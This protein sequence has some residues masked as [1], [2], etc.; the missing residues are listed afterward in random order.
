MAIL[1]FKEIPAAHQATGLQD[2]FE[3]FARDFLG[4]LGYK[5]VVD[6]S[7]GADG[8][9]DLIV[10]E[11]RTGIGGETVVRWLVSCKHKAHSGASVNA[12]DDANIR[13]RVEAHNCKGFIGFYSTLASAGLSDSL[14]GMKSRLECQ[15][16]D[17]EKI[18]SQI[19]NTAKGLDLAK[20]YF[21]NSIQA[22]TIQNPR[23][24]EIFRGRPSLKCAVCDKELFDQKDPGVITLWQYKRKD[25]KVDPEHYQKIVWTC[26]GHCDK[27]ISQHIR[28]ENENLIDG[29][30][31]I[32]D[33]M[34][35]TIFIKW[36]MSSLN[37]L[38]GEVIYSDEAFASLKKFL[39]NVFPHVARHL[40]DQEKESIR[41]LSMMP[42][43]LGGLGYEDEIP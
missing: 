15:V 43:F 35:P 17:R 32:A 41:S 23:P 18:E 40:T 34:M 30:E 38:Q 9:S 1:D 42:A 12:N 33:V 22:W 6:P 36:V 11:R 31:D 5:V 16:F 24:A 29:W 20:R 7:R 25:Y 28:S 10:E 13:D 3:L 4:H 37:Q 39:L 19:L 8:G 2:T 26:R 21:P 14:E 27:A